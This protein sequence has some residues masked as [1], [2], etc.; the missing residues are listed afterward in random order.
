MLMQR[1]PYVLT[2]RLYPDV[3]GCVLDG[4]TCGELS[5]PGAF[6]ANGAFISTLKRRGRSQSLAAIT[7]RKWRQRYAAGSNRKG[8]P[9]ECFTTS[10]S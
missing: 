1:H 3:S 8:T 7:I 5:L 4:F 2:F 6:E 9:W 10:L